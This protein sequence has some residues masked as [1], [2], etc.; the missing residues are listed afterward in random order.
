M[1]FA[2]LYDYDTLYCYIF[3]SKNVNRENLNIQSKINFRLEKTYM[4]KRKN[5]W[6]VLIPSCLIIFTLMWQGFN[7]SSEKGLKIGIIQFV[8]H[9][10]LDASRNGFVSYLKEYGFKGK[11]DYKNAQGDQA[12]CTLIANQFVSQDYDLVLAIATPAA[13]SV[14]AVTSEIPI[15]VTAVTNPEDAGLVKSNQTPG[16]N[17]TGTSD[18]A[19]IA[20]QISLIKKL[21]PEAQKVGILFSSN[22][23]NSKYQAEIATR[24]SEEIGLKPHLF[25]FSQM[26][27]IQQ[28]VESMLGKVDAIYTPTDNMVA[29]NME[30]I[31]KTAL[32]NGLPVI[33]GEVNLISKGA[34]GTFGMDYFELGKLTAKQAIKILDGKGKPESMP[35]EYLQNA[36]LSLNKEIIKKLNL[37]EILL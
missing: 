4:N 8:E 25:T 26:T 2:L 21:K 12:N 11:I 1:N 23:A 30:L 24:E 7:K 31:S 35:I 15:L 13:Q 14:A 3:S 10:A 5:L 34:T 36:K 22:E 18:L 6:W 28:V 33:C 20:K 37:E 9:E 17:V 19:P 32:Q 27:E 16:T 29:S